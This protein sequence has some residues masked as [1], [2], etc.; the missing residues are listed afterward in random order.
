VI[1][2]PIRGIARVPQGRP[3][4]ALRD[5]SVKQARG[6]S[7]D[8]PANTPSE[9]SM[10]RTLTIPPGK[11]LPHD[12][13][14]R[15]ASLGE[16]DDFNAG[17]AH[18]ERT[19]H[20]AMTHAFRA[21]GGFISSDDVAQ[22]LRGVCDQPVSRLARWIVSRSIISIGW[23]AQTLMPAFQFDLTDMSIVPVVKDVL[24]ELRPVF[25]DWDLALWFAAPN[26]CLDYAAPV[27][28]LAD[29]ASSVLQAA[30]TDR[31]IAS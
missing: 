1:G 16:R 9:Y 19:Q 30:R 25:D 20:E 31:F 10:T 6:E 13:V 18:I 23:R 2:A 28:L 7:R 12:V 29:D 4:A 27:A 15:S 3:G 8:R 17:F 22:G 21:H 14:T 26:A 11:Y 24:G 5:V